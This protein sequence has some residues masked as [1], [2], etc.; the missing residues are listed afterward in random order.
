MLN[1]NFLILTALSN[2]YLNSDN[3]DLLILPYGEAFPYE[4]FPSIKEYLFEGGG[5]L[6]T[7]GRPFWIAIQ[8]NN[9]KW[10]RVDIKDPFKEFLSPLGIRYYEFLDNEDKGLSVTTATAVTPVI[11]THGNVFPY[12]TPARDFYSL[13]TIKGNKIGLSVVLIKSWKN[14]YR[15]EAEG[16]PGKWC[17]I[18]AKGD[19]HPLNPKNDSKGKTL[20]QILEYLSFPIILYELETDLAAYRQNE[21]VRVSV[22]VINYGKVKENC[23]IEFE[24]SDKAERIVYK[25]RRAVG[26]EA[27]QREILSEIWRP[28]E[29]RSDFYKVTVFL[30]SH[31][32]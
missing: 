19:N 10:Q 3:F 31:N 30:T 9:G 27:G 4:A 8:S 22:K 7:A 24:I 14:P 18:G 32:N 25:K 23:V 21:Q 15:K 20:I 28:K 5:L 29:F 17:L 13:A 6:N 16:A 11:P 1:C 2:K 26:L 12:R